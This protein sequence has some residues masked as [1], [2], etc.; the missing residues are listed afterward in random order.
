MSTLGDSEDIWPLSG[1]RLDSK[2]EKC[3]NITEE[4]YK[5]I[6]ITFQIKKLESEVHSDLSD[7]S[8]QIDSNDLSNETDLFACD[9]SDSIS[10]STEA[11]RPT[12]TCEKYININNNEETKMKKGAT[13]VYKRPR[14][15]FRKRVKKRQ[16][17]SA[18]SDSEGSSDEAVPLSRII[19]VDSKCI[20]SESPDNVMGVPNIVIL[21]R[22]LKPKIQQEKKSPKS[23]PPQ[24]K[25][26][27]TSPPQKTERK[28][29]PLQKMTEISPASLQKTEV[30]PA[31]NQN[32]TEISPASQQKVTDISAAPLRQKEEKGASEWKNCTM[33]SLSFRGER[34]LRR[35]MTMSHIL[36]DEETKKS[37]KP[38]QRHSTIT[39]G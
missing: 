4:I 12:V 31:Y 19:E 20:N 30:S 37:S 32:V 3:R 35:H 6:N 36:N 22:D 34:G 15:R 25:T 13:T 11:E 9:K 39:S 8:D 24:T 38:E 14:K 1:N 29:T 33:C 17:K 21:T 28:P 27:E 16:S 23:I 2:Y 18:R 7:N 10:S 26:E 5:R